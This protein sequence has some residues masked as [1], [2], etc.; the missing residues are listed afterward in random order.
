MIR[1]SNVP[2]SQVDSVVK[3]PDH[4]KGD[5]SI[6]EKG[7]TTTGILGPPGP[8]GPAG[9]PGRPGPPGPVG[10]SNS[11]L[12]SGPTGPAGPP[13]HA[14]KGEYETVTKKGPIRIYDL[15]ME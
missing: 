12:P 1:T 5:P 6:Q 10:P 9:P 11:I 4:I 14:E 3:P 15:G 2:G 8:P 13:E 7:G